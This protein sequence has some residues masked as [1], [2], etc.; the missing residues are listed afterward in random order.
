MRART[1]AV[2][3]ADS[4]KL[5]DGS[6]RVSSRS[7]EE[8][9]VVPDMRIETPAWRTDARLHI[10]TTRPRIHTGT[11]PHSHIHT[12]HALRQ[13][14]RNMEAYMHADAERE[15]QNAL[16]CTRTGTRRN[17]GHD[18]AAVPTGVARKE[19][20]SHG[21]ADDRATN[22]CAVPQHISRAYLRSAGWGTRANRPSAPV[23]NAA[24]GR[25]PTC[26][27]AQEHV[28]RVRSDRGARPRR[29]VY[30]QLRSACCGAALRSPRTLFSAS[31]A[32]RL[33]DR[34]MGQS[35][36]ESDRA[37]DSHR[38]LGI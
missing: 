31:A 3:A 34:S 4:A 19:A 7:D 14:T 5:S 35:D 17:A 8:L 37:H 38:V 10:Q 29:A 20:D 24:A 28:A 21:S 11:I 1:A 13:V 22:H 12:T 30:R 33:H 25:S 16:V 36:R 2:G 23:T 27:R 18:T 15:T 26:E 9:Y 6:D 32:R